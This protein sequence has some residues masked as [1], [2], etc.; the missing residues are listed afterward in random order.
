MKKKF[1]KL[2]INDNYLSL[3]NLCRYIKDISTNKVF[4]SQTEIFCAIFG[5][6]SV[7]DSTVN[8]YCIGYRS[9]G[10]IY[11]DIYYNYRKKFSKN[12]LIMADNVLNIISI[13]DGNIYSKEEFEDVI[14]F[15]NENDNFRKLVNRLYNLAKNDSS[16]NKKFTIDV[17][18]MMDNCLYDSFCEILFYIVLEKQQPIYIDSLVKDTIENILNKTN[19]SI[20]DLEKFLNMQFMDGI[21]YIYS[22]KKMAKDGN[23]YA[24]FEIGMMEYNGDMVGYPRYNVCFDYMKKAAINN[25]PRANFMI[26]WLIYNKKVGNLDADD[27]KLAWHHLKV[28]KDCGS[29][30]AINNMGIAYLNGLVPGEKANEKIAIKY[31]EEAS[32][33]NYAYAFNNLGKIYE[34]RK[35]F[36]KAFECYLNSALL[37]ESWACNKIGN[38]YRL[39]ICCKKDLKQAFIFYNKAYE[40]PIDIMD[41]WCKYNL[42]KYFYLDGCYEAG[43]EKDVKRATVLFEEIANSNMMACIELIF[44]YS[45]CYLDTK[46]NLYLEK[47]NYYVSLC[48]SFKEYNDDIKKM[49]EDNLKVLSKSHIDISPIIKQGN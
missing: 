9:I 12:K 34:N 38:Y 20:N 32:S 39:A 3:G 33:Y 41:K 45:D 5:I 27:L 42:A 47:I 14:L 2:N 13:L 7:S 44:I 24:A 23:P 1:V 48:E 31:F 11:K 28:A 16:V 29:V 43:V 49:V 8:N 40:A 18:D 30:A 21:N 19:I 15:I 37:E 22:I 25:H 26:A 46:N 35:D 10:T 17:K 36:E 4:A 6:D